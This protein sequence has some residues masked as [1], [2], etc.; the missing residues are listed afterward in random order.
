MSTLPALH[1]ALGDNPA[2]SNPAQVDWPAPALLHLPEKILQFG[3]GT[4]LRS[5]ADYFIDRA[6]R[7]GMFGGR[8]VMVGS[9]D[10]RR[11]Q[12]LNEQ[13]GLYTLRVQGL[14][15]GAAVE[16][17]TVVSSVSR[18][19]SA[20]EDWDAVLA[21]AR[22]PNLELVISNTT[23][24]GIA[25]DPE[26]TPGPYAP[27]SFPGKLTACLYE[28]ARHHNYNAEAGLV[29]LPCELTER[30]GATLKGIVTQLAADWN[31]GV[32]FTDWLD[33]HVHF[34]DT[35]VDRISPGIPEGEVKDQ[36]EMK[37]GYTDALL[38]SAEV[39]R[40]WPIQASGAALPGLSFAEADPGIVLTDD[41]TPFR[42]RK[43]RILNGA[44]TI[45]VPL[46]FFA[47]E[48]TV[49]GM[50]N[51]PS[52]SRFV[53][54]VM[55]REIV[56]SLDVS[57]GAGFANEVLDRFRNPFLQ[58]RLL[59]ITLQMTSK[60]RMRILPSLRRYYEKSGTLPDR[61]LK[62]FA[63]YLW[64]MRV[65]EQDG[66]SFRGLHNGQWYPIRDDQAAYFATLWA[67]VDASDASQIRALV[68]TVLAHAAFWGEDLNRF[69]DM[70]DAIAGHLSM[71]AQAGAN[72]LLEE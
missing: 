4:F 69:P 2:F 6:N 38:T 50:M 52:T 28:R 61:I 17:Y 23:E 44:H 63:A 26:D 18:A 60:M 59:D 64:F 32:L 29:V 12:R 56:P 3:T 20:K 9:T 10:S 24:V 11:G 13:G 39:Y 30:N 53:E 55:H 71:L 33:A 8:I 16:R 41:I 47:G 68:G 67:N 54:G 34:C 70:A 42:E 35:L 40:L 19:L 46:A 43:V 36:V 72:A 14:E 27:R 1:P 25:Y 49:L 62:G 51:N 31:L 7:Q 48:E 45:S 5:F 66:S 58:H 22:D 15:E 65:V 37:L 21:V 57:G